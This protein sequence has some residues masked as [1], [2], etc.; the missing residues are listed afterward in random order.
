M[1]E[2]IRDLLLNNIDSRDEIAN[3]GELYDHLDY[4]GGLHE[5]IDSHIDIYYYDLRKWSVDN[6]EWIEEAI[7]SGIAGGDDDFHK[8][9]QGGQYM[10][11]NQDAI[12]IV[13]EL[14]QEYKNKL[15]KVTEVA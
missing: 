2:D 1:K 15:F 8:L 7:A 12:E 3:S 9:I 13:E 4:A 11:L 14:F 10:A 6:W 5:I